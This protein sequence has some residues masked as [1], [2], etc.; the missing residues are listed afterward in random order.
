MTMTITISPGLIEALQH[1]GQCDEDGT[2]CIVSREAVDEAIEI[3]QAV[4]QI[5]TQRDKAMQDY[6]RAMHRVSALENDYE[7]AMQ[8]AAQLEAQCERLRS[9][10]Q[11]MVKKAADKN[12]DGYRELGRKAAAAENR[13]DELARALN[14]L[15]GATT[16]V[17]RHSQHKVFID[18]DEE[19]C[20]WQ[21]REWVDYLLEEAD[22]A[23]KVLDPEGRHN[24]G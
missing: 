2:N 4:P 11:E 9:D 19:P 12:L 13:Q 3:L 8:G 16:S 21:R 15:I 5:E 18:G 24:N 20:Y 22:K 14:S 1:Q 23:R 10:I 6:E 7:G 17:N